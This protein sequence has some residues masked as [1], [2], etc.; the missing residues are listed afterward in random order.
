MNGSDCPPGQGPDAPVSRRRILQAGGTAL[1]GGLAGC[2]G[3]LETE[4]LGR[5]DVMDD[6]PSKVYVPTHVDEM[7]MVGMASAGRLGLALSYTY[8]H[9]F[10][11]VDGDR[12]NMVEV[13]DEDSVHLMVS[14]WDRETQTVIPSSNAAVTVRKDGETVLERTMWPMLSQTMGFHYGDNVGLAG[15]G[16][17]EVGVRFGPVGARRTGAFEAAFGD[18][19]APSF[20]FA[21]SESERNELGIDDE[22]YRSGR[23]EAVEPMEMEMMPVPQLPAADALPGT[24]LGSRLVGDASIV[25]TIRS[26]RPAG[27]GGDGAYLAVS[28]RTPYNRYPIPFMPLSATVSVEGDTLF[29]DPLTPT[30]DPE[31]GYHY[32]AAIERPDGDTAVAVT[33][34]N[35]AQ[36]A[37]HEGYETAFLDIGWVSFTE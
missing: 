36:V 24:V 17:Y 12:T 11:L 31:I 3:L 33:V 5:P 22:S 25:G 27:I 26:S 2:G 30:L 9:R 1:A 20:S 10:W 16:T 28:A 35:A 29:E 23:E 14:V 34:D 32:G 13:A 21:Y 19:V 15:D 37:R 6:R 18:Q 7:A 8:P 4:S